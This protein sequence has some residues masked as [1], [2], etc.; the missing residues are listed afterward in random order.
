MTANRLKWIILSISIILAQFNAIAHKEDILFSHLTIG[1]V[2]SQKT[3]DEIFKDSRGFIGLAIWNGLNVYNGYKIKTHKNNLYKLR[4]LTNN[5]IR[6]LFPD[7]QN[8]MWFRSDFKLSNEMVINYSQNSFPFEF[9][10][11]NNYKSNLNDFKY[12][13]KG[14]NKN[15]IDVGKDLVAKY[16]KLEPSHYDFHVQVYEPQNSSHYNKKKISVIIKPPFFRTIVFKLVVSVIVIFLILIIT[17]QRIKAYKHRNTIL[18][19]KVKQRTK[20]LEERNQQILEQNLEIKK[21]SEEILSKNEEINAQKDLLVDQKNKIELAYK[22]LS[23]YKNK[24]ENIVKERTQELIIAKE[25]AEESDRLKTSFLENL[26]HEIRTPLNAIVGFSNLA[27]SKDFDTNE[28]EYFKSIVESSSSGLLDLITAILEISNL[29][30]CNLKLH[31]SKCSIQELFSEAKL[32]FNSEI[33][34]FRNASGKNLKLK[35]S[36]PNDIKNLVFYSDSRRILQIL[37]ILINNSIKYTSEGYIEINCKKVDNKLLFSVKDSGIGIKDINHKIIFER[38]RKAEDNKDVMY[39]GAGIGLTIAS[40]L[41]E[42]LG[43]GIWVEST[44]GKGA[45]FTFSIKYS[46]F[47]E[48]DLS[49]SKPKLSRSRTD[50]PDLSSKTIIIAEDDNTNLTYL[51]LIVLPT[52]AQILQ[53]VNGKQ[54]VDFVHTNKVD[55]ILMDIRMPEMN[56]YDAFNQIKSKFP[57]ISIIAQT[58]YTHDD[59]LNQI[60]NA[61]FDGYLSKPI[62]PADLYKA[63]NKIYNNI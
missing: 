48:S 14:A 63:I 28:R 19:S 53:A 44:F 50:L 11:R 34:K 21:Q 43:G 13:L 1:D 26:S 35:I 33:M 54:V 4:N 2:F 23:N 3:I 18:E 31:N 38:F 12:V 32:I 41:S 22:E 39:R 52:K 17:A 45:K 20:E 55:L 59:V 46:P 8:N 61:G 62:A 49:Y 58:A 60:Y 16:T 42:L 30:S 36:I 7:K 56:G 15:W 6:C 37:T 47:V 51:N 29:E 10:A 57:K 27:F 24:L 5:F 25:K 40:K 9:I